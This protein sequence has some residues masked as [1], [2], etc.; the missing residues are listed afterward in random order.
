MYWL[1]ITKNFKKVIKKKNKKNNRQIKLFCYHSTEPAL[2]SEKAENKTKSCSSAG[3]LQAK[4]HLP[5]S[6]MYVNKTDT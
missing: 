5:V 1:A 6:G 3:L 2:S 4:R